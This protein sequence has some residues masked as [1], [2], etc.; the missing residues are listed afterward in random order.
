MSEMK[1]R[2]LCASLDYA[3]GKELAEP[4]ITENE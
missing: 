4:E 3:R 1:V 2:M